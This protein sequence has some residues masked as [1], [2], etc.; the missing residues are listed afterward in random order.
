M[1]VVA[2]VLLVAVAV[3]APGCA[4][5]EDG[6]DTR[7]GPAAARSSATLFLLPVRGNQ[8]IRLDAASGRSHDGWLYVVAPRR[9]VLAYGPRA[10]AAVA[11]PVRIDR[12]I[13]GLVAG[14]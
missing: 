3:A 2:F 4:T 12:P 11:L 10:D 13:F 8:L 7:P 14:G 1:R 5:A 6:P 9:R